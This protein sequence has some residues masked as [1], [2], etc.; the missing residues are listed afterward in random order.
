MKT[1]FIYLIIGIILLLA[2]I[3]TII[4]MSCVDIG[5]LL[6]FWGTLIGGL[7][8]LFAIVYSVEKNWEQQSAILKQG[9]KIQLFDKRYSVFEALVEA[10]R[11]IIRQDIISMY[12]SGVMQ[13]DEVQKKIYNYN[14][15]I[16][17]KTILSQTLFDKSIH[18][19]MIK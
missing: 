7:A 6:I 18:D 8:T 16:K 2:T 9:I 13:L 14:E 3:V 12:S 11:F 10:E 15:N 4:F 5:T 19:K 17:E 1:N